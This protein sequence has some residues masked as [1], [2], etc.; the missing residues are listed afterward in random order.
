MKF[1]EM[2]RQFVNSKFYNKE[3]LIIGTKLVHIIAY[4]KKI[5]DS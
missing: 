2:L 1:K 5:L 4:H 3:T